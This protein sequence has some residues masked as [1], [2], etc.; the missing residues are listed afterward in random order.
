MG[1]LG[2]PISSSD[3]AGR[4]I[5]HYKIEEQIGEGGMGVVY[6]AVDTVLSRPV[7]IK[8]LPDRYVNSAERRARFEREA[9]LL[10]SLDHR[11]IGMIHGMETAGDLSFLVLELIPGISLARRLAKDPP[12][13][14]ESLEIARQMAEALEA[15]HEKGVV[16]RDLKPANVMITPEGTVKVLDFGLA[17]ALQNDPS[18]AETE[19][20]V[21]LDQQTESG[22]ILG[23]A[24]YM[25]PEQA[26][27]RTVDKRADIW[28]FGAVLYEMLARRRAFQ[29]ETLSDLLAAVL[30]HEPDWKVLPDRMPPTVSALIKRCLQKDLRKRLR[31]I[32]DARI[33]LEE[34]SNAPPAE[35]GQAPQS[36]EG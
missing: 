18:G 33:E 23:T 30:A 27:G 5:S 31:D 7:A 35:V 22:V 9:K 11:N 32:G 17:K 28:A 4:T 26:R 16:H 19:A 14:K 29:G 24:A 20:T 8:V 25:S 34:A 3:L 15:A 6:R 36:P 1:E 2:A 13:A 12:D 10:A 21:T